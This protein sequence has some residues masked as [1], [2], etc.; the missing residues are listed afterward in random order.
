MSTTNWSQKISSLQDKVEFATLNWEGSFDEYLEI[1][2]TNPRVTRTAYQRVYDMILSHGKTEYIDNKKRLIRYH[3]FSDER[4]GGRDAVFGLDVPLMKLV[5]VFKAA[6]HGYGAEKRVILLHGPVGSLEVDHRARAQAWPRGLLALTRGRA[7]FVLVGVRR[8]SHPARRV[9]AAR[10][11]AS[12]PL[13]EEPLA[14]W[15]R[16]TCAPSCS[17]SCA[18]TGAATPFPNWES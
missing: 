5:N 17:P 13:N 12:S 16:E 4:N 9:D 6:A 8:E 2:R 14:S 11:R 3:F 10:P 18:P 15:S 7:V 1:V